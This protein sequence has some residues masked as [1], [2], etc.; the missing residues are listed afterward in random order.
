MVAE[1]P[2]LLLLY[3]TGLFRRLTSVVGRM[4][5]ICLCCG[6]AIEVTNSM[7]TL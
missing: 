6:M 3:L 4:E 2:D 1:D 5:L 7:I